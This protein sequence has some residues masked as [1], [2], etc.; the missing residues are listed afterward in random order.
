MVD[1]NLLPEELRKKEEKEKETA[2]KKPHVFEVKMIPAGSEGRAVKK[3]EGVFSNLFPKPSDGASQK[4]AMPQ[5]SQF[6]RDQKGANGAPQSTGQAHKQQST[7]SQPLDFENIHIKPEVEKKPSVAP[8]KKEAPKEEKKEIPKKLPTKNLP[9][10]EI[11]P[12]SVKKRH[13][14]FWEFLKSLFHFPKRQKFPKPQAK[15]I[16][17]FKE[18][19]K[20]IVA[21]T[22]AQKVIPV[23][24]VAQVRPPLSPPHEGGKER[25]SEPLRAPLYLRP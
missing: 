13:R 4:S 22:M 16:T 9:L 3:E 23:K 21:E 6:F 1:I 12:M 20:K 14:N 19:S 11:Y 7:K 5:K 17:V 25:G 2:Q 18:V 15:D 10:P 24:T 8:I